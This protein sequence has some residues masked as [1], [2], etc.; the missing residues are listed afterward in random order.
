MPADGVVTDTDMLCLQ[1]KDSDNHGLDSE[2]YVFY[3]SAIYGVP[4]DMDGETLKAQIDELMEGTITQSDV[5]GVKLS[6][7]LLSAEEQEK[8]TN[9]KPFLK[10]FYTVRDGVPTDAEG[11]VTY[12]DSEYG[13]EQVVAEGGQ[14][15]VYATDKKYGDEKGSLLVTGKAGAWNIHLRLSETEMSE[16]GEY[17]SV[18]FYIMA[19]NPYADCLLNIGLDDAN[20]NTGQRGA[21][22]PR[23]MDGD[24]SARSGGRARRQKTGAHA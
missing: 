13:T 16:F 21:S 5:D 10:G 22:D 4:Y 14:P 17:T 9:Y 3:I 18:R 11:R 8:V 19:E 24:R 23:R 15:V 20:L 12:F 6:Y 7:S 2:N 1:R